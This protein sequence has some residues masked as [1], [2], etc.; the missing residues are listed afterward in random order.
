MLKKFIE[1][2]PASVDLLMAGSAVTEHHLD[3][4]LLTF[5][6]VAHSNFSLALACENQNRVKQQGGQDTLR[7]TNDSSTN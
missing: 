4:F 3:H 7:S 2:A 5:Q 6:A 1:T